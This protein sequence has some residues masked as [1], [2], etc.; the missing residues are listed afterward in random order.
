MDNILLISCIFGNKFEIVHPSP[1]IKNSYFFTNNPMIETE[2]KNKGWNY[3]YVNKPISNDSI[4]SALQSKYIKFLEFLKD[5]PQFQNKEPIIYFDHK[6]NVSVDTLSEIKILINNNPNKALIIRQ[7]PSIKT[8]INHEIIEAMKQP[9]YKKNINKTIKFV[10]NMV[11]SGSISKNVRICNTGLL[12]YINKYKIEKLLNNV[13]NKCMEHRQ[14]ECQIYWSIFSQKYKNEIKEIS[15][16]VI[17]NI[18]R[19]IPV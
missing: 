7:T 15:W 10:N 16:T 3:I 1:D 13:Y 19:Q 2:V 11:S 6:E 12:I 5:F 8:T 4:V 17:Q 9:R 18:E 14:P